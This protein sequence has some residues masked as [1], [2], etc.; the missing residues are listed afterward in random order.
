MGPC[1]ASFQPRL[2]DAWRFVS[3]EACVRVMGVAEFSADLREQELQ[4]TSLLLRVLSPVS[5]ER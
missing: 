3:S 4:R 1:W 2:K 5:V